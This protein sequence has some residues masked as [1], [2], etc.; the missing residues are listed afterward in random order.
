MWT[1]LQ[2]FNML[3]FLFF[4]ISKCFQLKKKI[5]LLSAAPAC[6]NIPDAKKKNTHIEKN[7]H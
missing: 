3:T 6:L 7:K 2:Q 1:G 5:L 4:F